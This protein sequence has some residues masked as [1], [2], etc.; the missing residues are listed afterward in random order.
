M[1]HLR[2]R[3][4]KIFG[5]LAM[6]DTSFW[7]DEA[8]TCRLAALYTPKPP[9]SGPAARLTSSSPPTAHPTILPAR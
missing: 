5:P 7:V 1:R 8:E 3:R 6:T 2:P 4:D 9:P